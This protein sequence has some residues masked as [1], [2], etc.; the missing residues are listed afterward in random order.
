[1]SEKWG[2][3]Q[4][5]VGENRVKTFFFGNCIRDLQKERIQSMEYRNLFLGGLG[6]GKGLIG[7]E[8]NSNGKNKHFSIGERFWGREVV[9]HVKQVLS[10]NGK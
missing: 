4:L 8:K 7:W 1:M 3:F 5:E 6:F 10:S 9:I 2:T